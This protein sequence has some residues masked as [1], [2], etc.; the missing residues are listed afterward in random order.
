[1]IEQPQLLWAICLRL[2]HTSG[3]QEIPF[4]PL[5]SAGAGVKRVHSLV[6]LLQEECKSQAGAGRFCSCCWCWARMPCGRIEA[7]WHYRE[8][9]HVHLR[10]GRIEFMINKAFMKIKV[11]RACAKY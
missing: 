8:E 5:P 9:E 10:A 1:M 11:S 4:A 3:M 2:Y 6:L 7:S